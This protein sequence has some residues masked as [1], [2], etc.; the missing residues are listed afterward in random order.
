MQ[1]W[2]CNRPAQGGEVILTW[3]GESV[4]SKADPQGEALPLHYG[5]VH[6]AIT[7]NVGKSSA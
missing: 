4:I 2:R 7:P 5:W 3:H 1:Q 6:P